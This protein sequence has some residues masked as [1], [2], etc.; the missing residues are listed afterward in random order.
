MEHGLESVAEKP[1]GEPK[2]R[3]VAA[4]GDCGDLPGGELAVAGQQDRMSAT[5]A[6]PPSR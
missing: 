6:L 4:E 2:R 1:V 3:V 5:L